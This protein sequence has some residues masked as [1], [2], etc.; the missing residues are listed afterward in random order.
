[1]AI[2]TVVR[3]V[4]RQ[5][6]RVL[7]CKLWRVLVVGAGLVPVRG[8]GPVVIRGYSR[9]SSNKPHL[10]TRNTVCDCVYLFTMIDCTVEVYLEAMSNTSPHGIFIVGDTT[11]TQRTH[12]I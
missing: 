10:V 11:A 8:W 2:L 9:G 7:V 4:L 5:N 6:L 1:M 3:N 12:N